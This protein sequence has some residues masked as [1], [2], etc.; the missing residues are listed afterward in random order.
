[1]NN[2]H[3]SMNLSVLA[4]LGDRLN[5]AAFGL[6]RHLKIVKLLFEECEDRP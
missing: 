6:G 2:Q 5:S 3:L 1:M 4:I